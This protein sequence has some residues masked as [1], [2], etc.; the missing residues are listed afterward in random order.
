MAQPQAG[1]LNLGDVLTL[2]C[3]ASFAV[4][5]VLV[6]RWAKRG[7]EIQLTWMQILVV[8]VLAALLIP[9]E[10]PRLMFTPTLAWA[11]GVTALLA[12]AFGLWAQLRYQPR[13]SATAATI[14]YAFEPVFARIA[15]W[16]ILGNVPTNVTLVGAAFI[17][18]GMIFS[19]TIPSEAQAHVP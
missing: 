17:V 3:A 1:G 6:G 4:Q 8:A 12:T 9:V 7:S 13:I 11:L 5:V 2:F 14:I 10:Q 16:I 19:S 18:A 15:A